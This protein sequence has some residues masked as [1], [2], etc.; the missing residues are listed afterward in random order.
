MGKHRLTVSGSLRTD[1]CT[2][3]R[4]TAGGF[5]AAA[6]GPEGRGRARGRPARQPAGGVAAPARAAAG[7]ARHGD[8]RRHTPHLPRRPAGACGAARLLRRLLEPCARR[9]QGG[10][11]AMTEPRGEESME[12]AVDLAIRKSIHVT[13]A[14][15]RAFDVFAAGIGN[16]WPL[17]TH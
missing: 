12:T 17:E 15:E 11:R 10:G 3:R 13:A 5:R 16:W 7:R 2:R 9:L 8:P 6:L 14:P 4:D 1:G